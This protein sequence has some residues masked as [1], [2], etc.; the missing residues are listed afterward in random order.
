MPATAMQ[1]HQAIQSG[2]RT[3]VDI[4]D[5]TYATIEKTD[6]KIGA[7]LTLTRD[8]AYETAK[9]VDAKVKAGEKLPLLA[10]VPLAI[11][12]NINIRHT[13]LTCA[14][15]ILTGYVSPYNATVTE[16]LSQH[17]IPIVGKT[18]MDEFAMGSSNENSALQATHNPWDTSRVPGGSS[19]GSAA[20]VA[21]G[22]V[23]ISLGSDTGGSIRQPASLCGLVGIKG[24]YGLVS[25]Y[26]L[27]AFGSSLD[28]I[29]PFARNVED[30]V[31]LMDVIAGFDPK[32]S[33]S[34]QSDGG[35]FLKT[36]PQSIQGL[37]VGVISQ[38]KG[39]GMQPEVVEAMQQSIEHFKKLGCEIKD[40]TI[41]SIEYALS[42]YYII[43]PAEASSNLA[44]FDGVRYGLRCEDKDIYHTYCKTRAEGFGPEV[45][46]R[47]M[48]GTFVLSAGY[49][50]AY[51]GK[52]EKVR[53]LLRHEFA[54]AF[55]QVDVM[56]CPTSPTTAFKAG[57]KTNDPLS[58]Y[59]A[60]ISTIPVSMVGIPGINVPCGFDKNNLPIGLQIVAPH[61]A[62]SLLFRVAHAF[63]QQSGLSNLLPALN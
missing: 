58:M 37:K 60:D 25:R 61:N 46:R 49:Y 52:A 15:N 50:D 20:A 42:A 43:A 10:G 21:S 39:E 27:V 55:K 5:E 16:R 22:Q 33:T 23:P 26:G 13:P 51:Y 18:N 14:S 12:D 63:E 41:P 3:A 57:E 40:V 36:L 59:L 44:R 31:A 7:F 2:E 29:G 24:T 28:Q 35:N 11:K 34:I 32:D 47:I 54:E 62:E 17:L 19:G 53:G 9:T 8:L 30:A 38:L 48:I 4:L 1:L 6:P 45:K 56:I